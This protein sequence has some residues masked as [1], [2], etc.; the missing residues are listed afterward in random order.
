LR[1][2]RDIQKT[3][4]KTRSESLQAAWLLF[5]SED[6]AVL[7]LIRKM[8]GGKDVSKR[9]LNQYSLFPAKAA[10]EHLKYVP[11]LK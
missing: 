9:A 2:S 8:N 5:A 7:Y 1:I 10:A 4:N 3:K 11:P 6:V